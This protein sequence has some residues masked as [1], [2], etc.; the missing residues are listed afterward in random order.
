[1]TSPG[2]TLSALKQWEDGGFFQNIEQGIFQ[3]QLTSGFEIGESNGVGFLSGLNHLRRRGEIENM[4]PFVK[5]S[6]PN[7]SVR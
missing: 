1:M 3:A 6:R 4:S 2:M 5:L 7:G